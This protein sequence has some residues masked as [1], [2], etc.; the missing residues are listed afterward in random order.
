V[1]RLFRLLPVLVTAIMFAGFGCQPATSFPQNDEVPSDNV[2]PIYTS[3]FTGTF[4]G[5]GKLDYQ[6]T[7]LPEAE[8]KVGEHIPVPTYF[9]EAF[10]IQ[11]VY[12][13]ESPKGY[14]WVIQLLISDV[15]IEW[16][17]EEFETKMLYSIYW[18]SIPPKIDWS[19]MIFIGDQWAFIEEEE[20]YLMLIWYVN[21]HLMELSG[22]RQ[23]GVVELAKIF[24]SVE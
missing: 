3:T 9:P 22:T 24:S 2:N 10:K 23:I 7:T 20:E 21:G 5:Y 17:G 16:Q 19:D 8:K 1:K 15:P 18:N 4:A 11:E 14:K 13:R 6:K 12:I